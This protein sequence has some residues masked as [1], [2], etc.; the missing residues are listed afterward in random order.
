V[1][2]PGEER[3]RMQRDLGDKHMMMLRNHGTLSLGRTVGEAFFRIYALESACTMQV[4][5]LSMGR[6]LNLI[7]DSVI[8]QMRTG[9]K[10]EMASGLAAQFWAGMMRKAHR[11]CPG[12]DV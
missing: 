8:E 10:P 11:D 4:R 6:E 12:F 2:S 9:M 3:A 1:V 7:D 5:T